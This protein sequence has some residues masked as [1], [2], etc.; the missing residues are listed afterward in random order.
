MRRTI[1]LLSLSLLWAACTKNN[2]VS[3]VTDTVQSDNLQVKF[4][5]PHPLYG[6]H[7]TLVATTTAYNPGDTT[8]SFYIPVCWPIAWYSVQDS[9]G[10]TRLSYSAPRDL[11]CNSIIGYSILPH[12]SQ[13][14][15]LLS[16]M[17]AIV[18][19][20]ST[21]NPQG[22]YVLTVDNG[23]GTFSLTFTVN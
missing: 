8:V 17:V 15:S 20:D 18:D 9:S 3:P 2:P 4:S 1:I 22:S 6:V 10:T 12:Q 11:S 23:F 21:Q 14:I 16:V 5:I 13:Q 19:L 7:D